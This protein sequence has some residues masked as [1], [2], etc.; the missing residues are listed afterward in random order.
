MTNCTHCGGT[1]VQSR[2]TREVK[3]GKI[4]KRYFCNDCH[5]WFSLTKNATEVLAEKKFSAIIPPFSG[6]YSRFVVTGV[7]NNAELH[8]EFYNSLINYCERN[9]AK[10][11]IVPIRGK[12]YGEQLSWSV[13]LEDMTS[14]TFWLAKKLRLMA[15]LNIS[16]I[17]ENP[18]AG[19]DH[20]CKGDSLIV[21][22]TKMNM[23][24]VANDSTNLPAILHTTGVI[25]KPN[26]QETKSG[27]KAEYAHSLSAL[28][29]EVDNDVDS[30]FHVRILNGDDDGGFYDINGYY[31]GNS[32][33]PLTEIEALIPGDTHA[34]HHS[35]ETAKALYFDK[36]SVSKIMKPKNLILHDV[37]DFSSYSH[38]DAKDS[39][40][41][42]AKFIN[43]QD[44]VE[45]E[46]KYTIQHIIDITPDHC[47][48]LIVDSNHNSHLGRWLKEIDIKTSPR[49]AK[50]YH[51]LNYLMLE[52]IE[53]TGKNYSIPDPF[54]LW[55]DQYV[56]QYYIDPPQMKFLSGNE[57]YKIAGNI[58]SMHGHT[59]VNG[60]RASAVSLTKLANKAIIG[61][62]HSPCI[63]GPVFQVGTSSKLKLSYTN[64]PSGWH[65]AHCVIYPNGKRQM[66]FIQDG[67][68][69]LK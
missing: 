23:R 15:N 13:P 14:G 63:V 64:G 50:I 33:Q 69:R 61:H 67:I 58:I 59:G 35:P 53:K 19:I 40:I 65:S 45:L 16:P 38:H 55:T 20:L 41:K 46:L 30:G 37:L 62:S 3:G 22:H 34:M 54:E 56:K 5:N 57:D 18:L 12:T 17:I 21:A 4:Q 9:S 6:Q 68:W 66:I 26:Y 60:A 28:V 29:I 42:F 10:L 36:D 1:H 11:L 7:V 44:D 27:V 39:F 24:T 48:V 8:E 2:G 51:Q 47:D 25:T 43:G 31:S 52:E 32:H 49:N